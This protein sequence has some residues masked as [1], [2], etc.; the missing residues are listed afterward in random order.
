MKRPRHSSYPVSADDREELAREFEEFGFRET[1]D[2]N[3]ADRRNYY[4]VEKWDAAELHVVNLLHASMISAKPKRFLRTRPSAAPA[5]A[6]LRQC[7]RVPK[8]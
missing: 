1:N 3:E 6:E 2:P 7:I 8:R 5:A 4:K